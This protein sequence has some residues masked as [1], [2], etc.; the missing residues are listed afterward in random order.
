MPDY[1]PVIVTESEPKAPGWTEPFWAGV[2]AA[3]G[4]AT[5]LGFLFWRP[6][7]RSLRRLTR[8]R[9]HVQGGIATGLMWGAV[10]PL[11]FVELW[12]DYSVLVAGEIR[13]A[14]AFG[15]PAPVDPFLSTWP[16]G[17]SGAL[18]VLLL[19][20]EPWRGIQRRYRCGYWP[21]VGV[22]AVVGYAA[23]LYGVGRL[24]LQM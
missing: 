22:L 15:Q 19:A 24:V 3:F 20:L 21:A 1:G 13:M 18:L 6:A 5:A 16:F 2:A 23:A 10:V 9:L 14:T 8:H 12:F 4:Q 17:A 7:R 11:V